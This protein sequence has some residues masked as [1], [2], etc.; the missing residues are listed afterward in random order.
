V[1]R[2]SFTPRKR[3]TRQHVIADQSTNLV[4]RYIIDEG[5]TAQRVEKDYGYDLFMLTYDR[6][7]FIEPGAIRIQLKAA[8]TLDP[9]GTDYLFDLDVRDCNLWM[10]ELMPVFLVLF[11]AS[12][13]RAY[14]LYVQKYFRKDP[15]RQPKKGTKTVRVRIPKRQ[16]ATHRAVA[17]LRAFKQQIYDGLHG[18][19]NHA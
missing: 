13:R 1:A 11:D 4:E 10:L 2:P 12:R 7:G 16:A 6:Q 19:I 18:V 17:K 3:R 8:E 9:S 15:S 14:W 5:H